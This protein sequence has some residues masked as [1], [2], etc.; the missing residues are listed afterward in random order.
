MSTTFHCPFCGA[1]ITGPAP[2]E[3]FACPYCRA[4]VVAPYEGAGAPRWDG[5]AAS[6]R[7]EAGA[8]TGDLDDTVFVTVDPQLGPLAIGAFAPNGKPAVLRC[9]DMRAKKPLWE[10]LSGQSW[11]EN[12][13]LGSFQV[14]GR[15]LYV[16]NKRQLL[17]LDLANGNRKW[18]ATLSDA[19]HADDEL[20]LN[21]ADPFH[22]QGRGA[23]LVP[24]I[25]NMLYAFDRD[26]GQQIWARPAGKDGAEVQP[27]AGMGA[28]V[29]KTRGTFVKAEIVNPAYPTAIA[30]IGQGDWSMDLG[31]CT[32][33]GR[34]VISVIENWGPESDQNGLVCFDAVTGQIHFF[35]P[36]EDLEEEVIPVA[37]GQRVFAAVDGGNGLYVGP[38]GQPMPPPVPNHKIVAMVQAGPT[39]VL[40]LTKAH[41]TEVRR[42]VGIDPNTMGFRFDAG[43]AG[44]EPNYDWKRQLV[45]DGYSLVFVATPDDDLR[46]AELRSVDTSTG[47]QLWKRSVEFP[48]RHWFLNGALIVRTANRGFEVLNP[49]N[50]Q[51]IASLP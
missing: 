23:I 42:V 31:E 5:G 15:N 41:G 45:T 10:Q 44:A 39:L 3:A 50:G 26:S 17:C 6:S 8:F 46:N 35:D 22:S 14:I 40:M 13:K 11:V 12:L 9:W 51:P 38:R 24:T 21:I 37:T 7:E 4:K 33:V 25:D 36:V 49:Q 48:R 47:S 20:G 43:E 30:Q 18:Q 2:G 32:V 19:V 28:V 29:V 27:V 16:G 1:P 34:T